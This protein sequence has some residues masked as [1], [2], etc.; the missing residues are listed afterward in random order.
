MRFP[1]LQS[2]PATFSQSQSF[3]ANQTAGKQTFRRPATGRKRRFGAC[4]HKVG[5]WRNPAARYPSPNNRSPPRADLASGYQVSDF[6]PQ[7][8]IQ[9]RLVDCLQLQP[10]PQACAGIKDGSVVGHRSR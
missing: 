1:A 7:D 4:R 3:W 2:G 9:H 5:L 10:E 8:L 6:D